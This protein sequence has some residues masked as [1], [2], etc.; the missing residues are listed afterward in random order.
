MYPW[1]WHK[2]LLGYRSSE[3]LTYFY[4]IVFSLCQIPV[5]AD[6]P[7][8]ENL[9]DHFMV[10]LMFSTNI[11]GPVTLDNLM[12]RW[13]QREYDFLRTGIKHNTKAIL[14]KLELFHFNKVS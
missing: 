13:T 7:V 14:Q 11:T 6:L 4:F 9:Q 3:S 5:H 8:G 1:A 12:S 2:Q 10:P